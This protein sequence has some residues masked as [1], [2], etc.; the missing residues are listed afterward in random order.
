MDRELTG[1]RTELLSAAAALEK[2]RQ[3]AAAAAAVA[4]EAIA[5]L[6]KQVEDT[7]R[8][9][10]SGRAS[11]D[12][13]TRSELAQCRASIEVYKEQLAQV[14]TR[15]TF[16]SLFFCTLPLPPPPHTHTHQTVPC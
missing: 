13:S 11:A 10:Q 12:E 5:K 14:C 8:V 7:D 15:R 4:N 2:S 1:V 9:L 16:V 6:T 3:D